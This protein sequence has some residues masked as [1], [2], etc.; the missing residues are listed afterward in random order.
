M[1]VVHALRREG[2]K[3]GI[4]E[5]SPPAYSN[6]VMN[7]QTRVISGGG[8]PPSIGTLNILN[9]FYNGLVRNG[10][11][12]LMVNV[13]CI[14][15][16]SLQAALTPLIATSGNGSPD[17]INVNSWVNMNFVSGDLSVNG[18]KGNASNKYLKTGVI[19]I[20]CLG[21]QDAGVTLYNAFS[22]A[23]VGT[24]SGCNTGDGNSQLLFILNY[25][26]Y[27]TFFDVYNDSTGRINGSLALSGGVGYTSGN[28]TNSTT[29]YLYKATS[30]I[31][32]TSFG[33]PG[34][35]NS[36][37]APNTEY[38]FYCI[39]NGGTAG[40]FVA[41]QFSFAAIHRGLTEAQSSIFFNLIQ[42]MRVSMG[43]GY[44]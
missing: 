27:G 30:A 5:T 26:N 43:G 24:D 20:N 28:R 1:L 25:T 19:P 14:V 2:R 6:T 35:T 38:Y 31:S 16:D 17:G 18:L 15:P 39:N 12:S 33:G 10:I 36:G 34:G 22:E 42:A 44:A 4:N 11:D 9:T 21:A 13:N 41:K 8:S 7:W 32:H 23:S 3:F 37:A 29:S 40:G